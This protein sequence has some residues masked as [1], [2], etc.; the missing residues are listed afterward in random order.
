MDTITYEWVGTWQCR[1]QGEG[2]HVTWYVF[3]SRIA[4][5][6]TNGTIKQYNM[7]KQSLLHVWS[8]QD[9]RP[10]Y[11]WL[12][13]SLLFSFKSLP[14]DLV[15]SRW[16]VCLLTWSQWAF[17]NSWDVLRRRCGWFSVGIW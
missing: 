6:R 8:K 9:I 16:A 10:S 13:S 17:W 7:Q 14:S 11:Q 5:F 2:K 1:C 15:E 3:P 12:P 4:E